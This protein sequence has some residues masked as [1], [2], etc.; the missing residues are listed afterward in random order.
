MQS[1]LVSGTCFHR[2]IPFPS[3]HF[4]GL[5]STSVDLHGSRSE[6]APTARLHPRARSQRYGGSTRSSELGAPG[7]DVTRGRVVL[8]ELRGAADMER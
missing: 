5:H 2:F 8:H 1:G 6:R 4:R 7:V 3:H